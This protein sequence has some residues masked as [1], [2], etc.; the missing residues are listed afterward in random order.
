M[1]TREQ[2][3]ARSAG[4]CEQGTTFG[5]GRGEHC[6]KDAAFVCTPRRDPLASLRLCTKHA[7]EREA[8]GWHVGRMK[9]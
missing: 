2:R 8:L 4:R 1:I 3:I 9:R 6:P 5:T 7:G